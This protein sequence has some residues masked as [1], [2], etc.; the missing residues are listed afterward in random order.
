MR[1]APSDTVGGRFISAYGPGGIVVTGRSH[2]E[3]LLLSPD[4]AESPWGPRSLEELC[5]AHLASMLALAPQL[6]LIGTG[7]R[8]LRVPP[9]V[10]APALERGIGVEVMA[11]AA[12]CRTYNVLLGEGRRVV[13][14][15]LPMGG[16]D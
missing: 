15:L 3:T 1:F 7:P 2:H 14:L 8:G 11:T 6:L 13:A 5:D 9:G 10:V 16:A 12:A 4:A